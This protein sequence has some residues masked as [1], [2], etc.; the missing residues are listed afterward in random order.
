VPPLF[1]TSNATDM[2]VLGSPSTQILFAGALDRNPF[3]GARLT[4]G[5]WLDCDHDKAIEFEGFLLGQQ[6]VNF[7]ANSN[8][9]P[10]ISRPFF[11]VV[12]DRQAVE[13]LAFPG[14]ATGTGSFSAPSSLWGVSPDLLCKLCCGCD[15]QISGLVGVRYLDLTESIQINENIMASAT[16]PAPFAN[17][18]ASLTDFFGTRNQFI[19]GEVGLTGEKSWGPW[20]VDFRAKIA[21]GAT[22][23]TIT[24]NGGQQLINR[25][26]GQVQNFQGGLLALNS[27]IG[28]YSRDSFAVVPELN[29][30]LGYQ[31]TEHIRASIGY[32]FLY[33]SS[34]VRPGDQI[35]TGLDV[36]RIPNFIVPP[37]T[38]TVNRHAVP[39]KETDFFATGLTFSLEF[40]F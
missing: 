26:T 11:D 20:F 2:G 32:D 27:N 9:F 40:T 4:A 35:D 38:P 36:N 31:F 29:L 16:A 30:H 39:F 21:L 33:W 14:L 3:S 5:Y 25:V 13:R 7:Q 34:V 18:N 22:D 12:N 17:T 1:T 23:E 37:G 15:Y 24:I 8:Q 6:G 28:R 19:G 10:V